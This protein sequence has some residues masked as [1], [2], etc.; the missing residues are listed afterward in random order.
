MNELLKE[1][2]VESFSLD[3][4]VWDKDGDRMVYAETW[5]EEIAERCYVVKLMAENELIVNV[6]VHGKSIIGKGNRKHKFLILDAISHYKQKVK[7]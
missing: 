6:V 2:G 1:W 5:V 4:E 7:S 3:Y